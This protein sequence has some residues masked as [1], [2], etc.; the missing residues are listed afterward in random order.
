MQRVTNSQMVNDLI[1]T[2]NER[3]RTLSDLQNQLTTGK[4]VNYA[5]DDPGAAGLILELRNHLRQN[6]QFQENVDSAIGWLTATESTLQQLNEI[7]TQ[8]RADAVEGSNQATT[9]EGMMALA[10]E[11]NSYL[12][13]ILS[14]ANA[15]YSGKFLFGGTNT[16]EAAF[17]AMRDPATDWI[18]SVTANPDG[19]SG[20]VTRQIDTYEQMQINI[21]GVD[22]FLPN[23]TG[24]AEDVFQVL[25]NLRDALQTGDVDLVGA[26]ITQID[27]VMG[28]ASDFTSLAGSRVTRLTDM[29]LRLLTNETNLTGQLSNVEDADL[30]T[31][32]TEMTLEQNAYQAALNVGSMIIQPSLVNFM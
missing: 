28:N 30:V 15:D 24:G 12:E 18:T 9:P 14:L 29:Q 1:R 5:S 2:L 22:L 21:G 6:T 13:N 27:A 32:M 16:D 4:S 10:D 8:A 19:T 25:I 11:V 17:N 20:A 3:M 31:L 26:T 7:L 23:G